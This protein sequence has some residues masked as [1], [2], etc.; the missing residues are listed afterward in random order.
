MLDRFTA[1]GEV[2]SSGFGE[3][4]GYA[5]VFDVVDLQGD[6]VVPGAFADSIRETGGRVPVLW[7][8]D[9]K[10]PIGF[11]TEL[12]EDSRGLYFRANLVLDV[13]RAREALALVRA[14][15][16]NGVSIGYTVQ[17]QRFESG[18]RKLLKIRLLELSLV[19]FAA[20]PEARVI[21]KGEPGSPVERA[22]RLVAEFGANL[23]AKDLVREGVPVETA[24]AVKSALLPYML[25][26]DY[27][28]ALR[29]GRELAAMYLDDTARRLKRA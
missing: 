23:V 13:Q 3:I 19:T 27:D 21:R 1:Q 14:G 12:R 17:K 24:M 25:S 26:M 18:V 28:R 22:G 4:E 15:A 16:I 29:V 5:S 2:K 11:T 6:V 8:H 7:Q 10:E 20:N 9:T